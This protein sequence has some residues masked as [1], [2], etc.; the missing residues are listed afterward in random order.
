MEFDALLLSRLQFAF[1]IAFHIIF[2][3]FTI[4]LASW[5]AALEF[6]SLR[7]GEPIYRNLYRFWVT[8][9]KNPYFARATVNRTWWRLFGRGVVN[10]VDDMHAANPP[11]HPELL[12]LLAKRFAESGFDLKFL[13]RAIVLSR[14]Y[15]RTSRPGVCTWVK[16]AAMPQKSCCVHAVNGW[17]WHWAQLSRTPRK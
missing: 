5:L 15:Q 10:P 14:A 2:P 7:T 3:A 1:T 6:Q 12:D 13:T 9:P 8:S 11:S 4:G 17:S 16:N